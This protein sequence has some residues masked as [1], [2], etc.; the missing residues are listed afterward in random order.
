MGARLHILDDEPLVARLYARALED[1]DWSIEISPDP[2]Q[3]LDVIGDVRP[4]FILTDMN[5]P[6]MNA[7]EFIQELQ[8]LKIKTMPIMILSASA[9]EELVL[10]GLKAGAD[11]F[12]PKGVSFSHLKER[13]RFWINAGVSGMTDHARDNALRRLP[14][15]SYSTHFY[16]LMDFPRS[17]TIDRAIV[18]LKDQ[19]SKPLEEFNTIERIRLL[20]VLS[21]ILGVLARTDP[22]SYLREIDLSLSVL[23]ALH[24]DV[25]S[26]QWRE[27]WA[28]FPHL[29]RDPTFHQAFESLALEPKSL[30]GA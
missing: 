25:Q 7:P 18:A 9:P 4:D 20:G 11:D 3:A 8:K 14:L 27:D 6:G 15:A 5:M 24:V 21:G 17:L 1:Q 2:F 22:V 12:L 13:V 29:S 16:M 19:I 26:D 30:L 28:R 10:Q 23:E